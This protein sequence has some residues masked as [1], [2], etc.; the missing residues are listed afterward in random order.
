MNQYQPNSRH[1]AAW[2]FEKALE[3]LEDLLL[4]NESYEFGVTETESDSSPGKEDT[5]EWEE[6]GADLEQFFNQKQF[7]TPED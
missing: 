2:E 3:Q 5:D 1:H 6:A 7:P 4:E